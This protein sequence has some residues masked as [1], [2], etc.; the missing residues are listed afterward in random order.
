MLGF[1]LG[2]IV[3]AA[4]FWAYRFWKGEE[5]TSWDQPL[6]TSGTD[7]SASGSQ[8]SEP[9]GSGTTGTGSTSSGSTPFPE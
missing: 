8:S 2:V 7:Y 9:V 1:L 3:G 4:G 6:S 5:D